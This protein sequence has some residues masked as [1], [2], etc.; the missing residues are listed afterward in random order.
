MAFKAVLFAGTLASFTAAL[1]PPCLPELGAEFCPTSQFAT[2]AEASKP[3]EISAV[4]PETLQHETELNRVVF[5]RLSAN[6]MKTFLDGFADASLYPN[7]H[8]QSKHGLEIAEEIGQQLETILDDKD[9]PQFPN[10]VRFAA[11]KTPQQSLVWR[12]LA[13]KPKSQWFEPK[14]T[15]VVGYVT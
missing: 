14:N 4:F 7:R 15:I 11:N 2:V 1:V 8:C 12:V 13:Q 6:R 9:A 5:P 3:P 10:G